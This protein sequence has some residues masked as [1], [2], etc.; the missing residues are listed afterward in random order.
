MKQAQRVK[1]TTLKN[2]GVA[3]GVMVT[4]VGDEHNDPSSNPD[5]ALHI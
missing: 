1:H 5:E 4:L 2:S 3:R